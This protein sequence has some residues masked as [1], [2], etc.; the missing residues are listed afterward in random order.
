MKDLSTRGRSLAL[1]CLWVAASTCTLVGCGGGGGSKDLAGGSNSGASA[2]VPVTTSLV[3]VAAVGAP[4]LG[5]T[6]TVVDAAGVT[7][8]T[9]VTD[10]VHGQYTL[11]LG[12]S[13]PTFPLLLQ[14]K[15]VDMAGTPVVLYSMAQSLSAASATNSTLNITPLTNAVVAL[16]LGDEPTAQFKASLAG[17]TLPS[18]LANASAFA[19]A[20]TF[21]KTAVKANLNNAGLTTITTVDLFK[22]TFTTN[23]TGMDAA[24]EGLHLQFG[25][26]SVS[27]NP[28]LY[29]SNKLILAGSTEVAVDLS[30]ANGNLRSSS[31]VSAQATTSTLK[32]TTVSA[33]AMANVSFMDVVAVALNGAMSLSNVLNTDLIVVRAPTGSLSGGVHALQTIF[34]SAF[35]KQDGYDNLQTAAQLATYSAA[36]KQLSSFQILGCLDATITSGQCSKISVAALL[37]GSSTTANSAGVFNMVMTYN[38]STGWSFIGNGSEAPWNVY[39]STWA[40][41]DSTGALTPV[42]SPPQT[43]LLNNPTV[44]AQVVVAAFDWSYATLLTSSHSFNFA[45]CNLP[46]GEAMCQGSTLGQSQGD[47]FSDQMIEITPG[48]FLGRSDLTSGASISATITGLGLNGTTTSVK[49]TT[50]LPTSTALSLYPKPDG[51]SSSAPLS[52][53]SLLSGFSMTW[54]TWA[55]ANPNM[56]LIEVRASVTSPTAPVINKLIVPPIG[57]HQAT[58]PAITGVP[59]DAMQYIL[60]LVA[61]DD[62]GRRYISKI[63]AQ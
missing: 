26:D 12:T 55:A 28:V 34:S 33:T 52:M 49:L 23:K 62:Q 8:G 39:P 24:I 42:T 56:R 17:G 63:V 44:G 15:G 50:N 43:A 19:A 46:A 45:Y 47:M 5:A 37:Y 53:G 6:I 36:G 1:A 31:T 32:A 4:L 35:T 58:L 59:S 38:S 27:G 57:A 14:A 30:V 11:T 25:K 22:D 9:A 41:F 54:D 48:G 7:Q 13:T 29:L 10:M 16:M 51:L 40:S 2:P 20:H 21:V 3:G 18:L 61:Q 60:W